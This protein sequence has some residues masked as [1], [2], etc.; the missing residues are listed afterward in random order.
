MKKKQNNTNEVYAPNIEQSSLMKDLAEE[1]KAVNKTETHTAEEVS[2]S[3]KIR[4][5]EE[6]KPKKP[7][8][9]KLRLNLVGLLYLTTYRSKTL[10][11]FGKSATFFHYWAYS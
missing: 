10:S 5:I 8:L 9:P 3:Q 6:E 4:D 2:N 7:K 1:L 11:P